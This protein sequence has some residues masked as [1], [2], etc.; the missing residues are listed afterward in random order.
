MRPISSPK[1]FVV[2]A[3]APPRASMASPA[4]VSAND[5]KGKK[6]KNQFGETNFHDKNACVTRFSFIK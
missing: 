2:A 5:Y 6:R 1:P 4:A 3:A